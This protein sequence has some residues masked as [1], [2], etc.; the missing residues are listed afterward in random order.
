MPEVQ[1]RD[2]VEDQDHE[3]GHKKRDGAKPREHEPSVA[4]AGRRHRNTDN[5]VKSSEK[6]CE[7]FDHSCL[8]VDWATRP[9]KIRRLNSPNR[10]GDLDIHIT[11]D[12]IR[13]GTDGVGTFDELFCRLLIG[14]ADGHGERGGQHERTRGVAAKA[15]LG[16]NFDVV[17]GEMSYLLPHHYTQIMPQQHSRNL[18]CPTLPTCQPP[19]S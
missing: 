15:N 11:L 7:Q 17:I 2:D 8:R 19:P 1:K 14:T 12:R 4:G 6:L 9:R 18:A 5:V 10:D 3:D 16:D 13:V